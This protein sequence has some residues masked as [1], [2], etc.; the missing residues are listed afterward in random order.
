M[1]ALE[2]LELSGFD[3]WVATEALVLGLAE[4]REHGVKC[5]ERRSNY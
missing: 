5:T 1:A 4:I 2:E 3:E